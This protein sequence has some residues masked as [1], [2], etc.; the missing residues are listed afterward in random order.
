[1]VATPDPLRDQLATL[2]G[3][4]DAHADFDAAVEGLPP[5]LRGRTPPGLPYS[6][7]Q[8]VEHLRLAQHDI[9]DFCRNPEYEEMTWPDDYW[10]REAAPPSEAAWDGTLAGFRRDREELRA[11][12]ADRTLD[13]FAAIP[14][15]TGQTYLRELLLVADHNAYHVG[16][17]IAVRRLLGAWG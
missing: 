4:H 13:L 10:P 12:A 5:A 3:W 16:Q 11:L 2:L 6:P 1:M 14:H 17:L 7:W 8:L 15:G 9:L